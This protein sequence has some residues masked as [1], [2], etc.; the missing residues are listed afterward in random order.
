M[1]LPGV[2]VAVAV[3]VGAIQ[4]QRD[5]RT[6]VVASAGDQ[7]RAVGKQGGT[8]GAADA[9]QEVHVRP[10]VGDRIVRLDRA[11]FGAGRKGIATGQQHPPIGQRRGGRDGAGVQHGG[12]GAPQIGHGVIDLGRSD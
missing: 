11:G 3:A 2:V 10:T 7:H 12:R 9:F 1:R 4:L 6:V 8:P 5:H